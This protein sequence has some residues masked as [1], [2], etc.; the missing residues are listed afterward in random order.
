MQGGGMQWDGRPPG[1]RAWCW[2]APA[3]ARPT[4]PRRR[5]RAPPSARRSDQGE[6]PDTSQRVTLSSKPQRPLP[7]RPDSLQSFPGSVPVGS[8][9]RLAHIPAAPPVTLLGAAG[10]PLPSHSI[11]LPAT[12]GPF[13]LGAVIDGDADVVVLDPTVSGSHARLEVLTRG[14]GPDAEAQLVVA[15]LSST[16]GTY[17]NGAR[18]RPWT[19]TVLHPGDVLS[20]ADPRVSY[21]VA[22]DPVRVRGD[23]PGADAAGAWYD[24]EGGATSGSGGALAG[25]HP[26]IAA[27]AGLARAL[28]A[29]MPANEPWRVTDPRDSPGLRARGLARS[30]DHAGAHAVLLDACA[31]D[32]LDPGLWAQL[33]NAERQRARRGVAGTS[34]GVARAFYRA[35]CVGFEAAWRAGVAAGRAPAEAVEGRV[36]VLSSWAQHEAALRH[37]LSARR[38]F[39]AA[40]AGAMRHPGGPIAAGAPRFL[41]TWA[42]QEWQGGDAALAERLCREALTI[43]ADNKYL[44]TL[45]GSILVTARKFEEARRVFHT[46]L[47]AT[48]WTHVPTLLGLARLESGA[49]KM[50][51][52]RDLFKRALDL[53]PDSVPLLQAWAVA[54][55][56][57][58]SVAEARALFQQCMGIEPQSVEALHAWAKMEAGEGD[59][60]AARRLYAQGLAAAPTNCNVLADLA[61][62]EIKEGDLAAAQNLLDT[63]MQAGPRHPRT[64]AV[65]ARLRAAQGSRRE[66]AA[67][68]MQAQQLG[69]ARRGQLNA[70]RHR[71]WPDAGRERGGEREEG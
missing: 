16:N 60:N 13:V 37:R 20:L 44:L 69:R 53:Q 67:L 18:L 26:A 47:E 23:A 61:L 51:L 48:Q 58:G 24:A 66:A 14:A 57:Y 39:R 42:T 21:E 3:L 71:N 40:L 54:E 45:L 35:S 12:P 34:A 70:I 63:A 27:A 59:L 43:E 50:D 56:R 11:P 41:L 65:C 4:R 19:E 64:L 38:L 17:I 22:V 62:L 7:R 68:S 5:P 15:D 55:S 36:R 1:S 6:A 33:A 10:Q 2:G 29:A 31:R 25:A 8:R 30:G 49:L 46:A 9:W 28:L 52:A 32:P